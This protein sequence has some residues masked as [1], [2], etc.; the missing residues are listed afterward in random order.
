[1][2]LFCLII[3]L[4]LISCV[5][6]NQELGVQISIND[7]SDSSFTI[8]YYNGKEF[9][10][11]TTTHHFSTYYKLPIGSTYKDSITVSRVVDNLYIFYN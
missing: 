2:R 5:K 6:D 7:S 4:V 11:R 8:R 10:K 1:M 9:I 3:F